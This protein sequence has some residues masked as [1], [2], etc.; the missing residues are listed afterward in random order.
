MSPGGIIPK[1]DPEPEEATLI[2]VVA[3]FMLIPVVAL[4]PTNVP[5]GTSTVL[6]AALPPESV[7]LEFVV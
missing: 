7:D 3:E 6:S 5:V 4:P 1:A 2:P